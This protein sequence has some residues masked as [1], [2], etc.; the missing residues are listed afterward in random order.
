MTIAT[1]IVI[2][3]PILQLPGEIAEGRRYHARISYPDGQ[4]E[5]LIKPLRRDRSG[6]FWLDP[7]SEAR[8]RIPLAGEPGVNVELIGRV[9]GRYNTEP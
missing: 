4:V 2:L 1:G 3:A 9:I 7:Q 6:N 5:H 8:P